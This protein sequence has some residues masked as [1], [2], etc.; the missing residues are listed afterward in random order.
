MPLVEKK[1][2]NSIL[3]FKFDNM[4]IDLK[5]YLYI[6]LLFFGRLRIELGF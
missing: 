4:E 6:L 3:F 1:K 2:N 5:M